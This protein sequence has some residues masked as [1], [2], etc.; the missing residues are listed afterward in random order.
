[1]YPTLYRLVDKG[2]IS[3]RQDKVGKRKIRV[4][5]HL[6]E[7]GKEYLK[8]IKKEYYDICHGV[9]LILGITVI[10]ALEEEGYGKPERNQ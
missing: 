7:T 8:V 4:Y 1:M 5:Y 3:D 10:K 9:L 2:I 6:E